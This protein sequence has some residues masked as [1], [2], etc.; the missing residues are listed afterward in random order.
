MSDSVTAPDHPVGETVIGQIGV[1]A[2]TGNASGATGVQ[3]TAVDGTL[4]TITLTTTLAALAGGHG[5]GQDA[6]RARSE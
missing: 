1:P 4:L 6:R 5:E 2:A 3:V